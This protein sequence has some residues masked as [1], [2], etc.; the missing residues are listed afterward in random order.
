MMDLLAG[1]H[2][3]RRYETCGRVLRLERTGPGGGRPLTGRAASRRSRA[4]VESLRAANWLD[5]RVPGSG[6]GPL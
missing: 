3:E 5:P 4:Q 6:D 2:R 1:R